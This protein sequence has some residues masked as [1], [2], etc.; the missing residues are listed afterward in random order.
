MPVPAT[1]AVA[2]GTSDA[3]NMC[4]KFQNM[5]RGFAAFAKLYGSEHDVNDAV[6]RSDDPTSAG[7][8]AVP[9]DCAQDSSGAAVPMYDG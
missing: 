9:F 2:K 8:G 4:A 5:Y 7:R 1:H 6:A 3:A